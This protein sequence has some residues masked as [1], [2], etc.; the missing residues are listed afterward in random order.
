MSSNLNLTIVT[1]ASANHAHTLLNLVKNLSEQKETQMFVVVYDLGLTVEQRG[2]LEDLIILHPLRFCIETFDYSKYP[3]YFDINV[4][5]G[6]YAWKPAIVFQVCQRYKG[7]VIWMDSGNLVHKKLDNLIQIVSTEGLYNNKSSGDLARWTHTETLKY[8]KCTKTDLP[9]RN[10]ACIGVNYNLSWVR[11][12][13]LEWKS[14]ALIQDCIAPVGS[15]WNNHR[16]DQAIMSVLYYKYKTLQ[17][18]KDDYSKPHWKH[19]MNNEYSIHNDIDPE[20]QWKTVALTRNPEKQNIVKTQQFSAKDR[21]K[22]MNLWSYRSNTWSQNGEDG[23][24]AHLLECL[25]ID[26][27]WVCEFGAADGKWNSNTFKLVETKKFEAV[28]IEGDEKK[29]NDL[30]KLVSSYP[31]IHALNRMISPEKGHINS[32]DCILEKTSIPIDFDLLSIDIDSCDYHVWNN[33]QKY[34][35]KIVIIEIESSISP[36]VAGWI[37]GHNGLHMSCYQET[38]K[39]GLSKGYRL[40]CHTGN[41]FFLREDLASQVDLCPVNPIT[42]PECYMVTD[43]FNAGMKEVFQQQQAKLMTEAKNS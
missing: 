16:Y 26:H 23:I 35:P 18:F 24:I 33:V 38:V 39:L 14:A 11:E 40:V 20:P 32:L 31:N 1:A 8:L 27:G 7:L 30:F 22:A 15:S 29:C 2:K 43:W 9:N 17:N 19:Y 34:K 5:A 4:N 37:H 21:V 28:Y 3:S 10:A 13:V 42:S 6:Y 12:F 25:K 36:Y 41:L